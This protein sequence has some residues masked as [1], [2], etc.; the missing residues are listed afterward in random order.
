VIYQSSLLTKFGLDILANQKLRDAF[1][2]FN[3]IQNFMYIFLD[4]LGIDEK[5]NK[6]FYDNIIDT[7][8]KFKKI[9]IA[10]NTPSWLIRHFYPTEKHLK[11]SDR[12]LLVAILDKFGI[13]SKKTI[14]IFNEKPDLNIIF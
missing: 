5:S 7:F 6:S 11:K 3:D 4:E 9:K 10:N 1:D 12:K 13:K 14:K 2:D 8:I